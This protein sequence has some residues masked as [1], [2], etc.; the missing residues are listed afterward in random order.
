MGE[1]EKMECNQEKAQK[2]TSFIKQSLKVICTEVTCKEK[3]LE[4]RKSESKPQKGTF[5]AQHY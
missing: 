1:V 4:D 3:L 2:T 5:F